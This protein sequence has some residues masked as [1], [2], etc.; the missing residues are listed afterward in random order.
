M[1][2]TGT[3]GFL[4]DMQQD[5]SGRGHT[6]T[7]IGHDEWKMWGL[8]WDCADVTL[9]TLRLYAGGLAQVG[10]GSSPMSAEHFGTCVEKTE[11]ANVV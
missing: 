10:L 5:V 9:A 4:V 1:L 6:V 8:R 11:S 3:S 7:G 2:V